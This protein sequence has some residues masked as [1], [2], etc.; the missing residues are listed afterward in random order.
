MC[1]KLKRGSDDRRDDLVPEYVDISGQSPFG[2]EQ[3]YQKKD[4]LQYTLYI[5]QSL[6]FHS[7]PTN[8]THLFHTPPT[9]PY[10]RKI[11]T[12]HLPSLPTSSFNPPSQIFILPPH[13]PPPPPNP[14]APNP[15]HPPTSRPPLIH[16]HF[17]TPS[18]NIQEVSQH[19]PLLSL[20]RRGEEAVL[21][22]LLG[23]CSPLSYPL[24]PTPSL[25][26][27]LPAST[28]LAPQLLPSPILPLSITLSLLQRP[29]LLSRPRPY[30]HLLFTVLSFYALSRGLYCAGICP[31]G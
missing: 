25:F 16:H 28:L 19:R 18:P 13:H 11:P 29:P 31:G 4:T 15:H 5:S 24:P 20:E 3:P 17:H 23:F 2:Y 12:Q 7:L 14:Q 26:P 6:P 10:P 27:L 21:F 1:R 8:L 30:T 22:R 9:P